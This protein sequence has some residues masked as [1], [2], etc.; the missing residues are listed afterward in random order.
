MGN[1]CGSDQ[2]AEGI[3]STPALRRNAD[4]LKQLID[5]EPEVQQTS[6]TTLSYKHIVRL[7]TH[8][9]AD[10]HYKK[11]KLLG[12]GAFGEVYKCINEITKQTY[13]IKIVKKSTLDPTLDQLMRQELSILAGISHPNIMRIYELLEDEVN[14]YVVSEFITGGEL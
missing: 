1:C 10:M 14:Y 12:S 8:K 4:S 2:T 11:E 7:S 6:R 3:L 9:Q 13:A 5:E